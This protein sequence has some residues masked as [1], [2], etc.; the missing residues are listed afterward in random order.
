MK[1]PAATGKAAESAPIEGGGWQWVASDGQA[2]DEGKNDASSI[3]PN[4]FTGGGSIPAGAWAWRTITFGLSKQ[5]AIGGTIVYTDGA[6][7]TFRWKVPARNG[8]PGSRKAAG[9]A[10]TARSLLLFVLATLRSRPMPS[11]PPLWLRCGIRV[12]QR[13]EA[14]RAELREALERRVAARAEA[15][16]AGVAREEPVRSEPAHNGTLLTLST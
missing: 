13:M 2:L 5:Q 3:A 15:L 4:G 9:S 16:A 7:Q 8:Q 6:G 12:R 10:R 1:D 14:L 11:R